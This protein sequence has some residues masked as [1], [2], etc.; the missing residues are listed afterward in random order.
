MVFVDNPGK[1]IDLSQEC[2]AS[3]V[4]DLRELQNLL[5]LEYDLNAFHFLCRNSS[6]FVELDTHLP[7]VPCYR[8]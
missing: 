4:F 8:K 5:S 3:A 6:G 2:A 1:S 7:V